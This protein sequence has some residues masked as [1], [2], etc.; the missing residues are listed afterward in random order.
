MYKLGELNHKLHAMLMFNDRYQ[1]LSSAYCNIITV[2]SL[3]DSV[4][5]LLEPSPLLTQNDMALPHFHT[6]RCIFHLT[7]QNLILFL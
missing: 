7:H 6:E 5:N 1:V 2:G 4:S 3:L